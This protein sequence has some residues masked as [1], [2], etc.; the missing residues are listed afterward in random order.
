MY[1]LP[2]MK[3]MLA[4]LAK[5]RIFTKLGL[6]EAY[7]R[8]RVK[9]E[10]EWKTAFNCNLG[11]YQFQLMPFELQGAPMVFMQLINNILHEHLY[12][13]VLVYLNDI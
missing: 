10:D 8:V 2:L 7:Y 12:S 9:Q 3:N 1:P 5:S 4:H 6:R 11:S 13:G